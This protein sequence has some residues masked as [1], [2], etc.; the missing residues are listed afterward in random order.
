[1]A[2]STQANHFKYFKQSAKRQ[3]PVSTGKL[4]RFRFF[5]VLEKVP[6]P[7]LEDLPSCGG[8]GGVDD[9]HHDKQNLATRAGETK[10]PHQPKPVRVVICAGRIDDSRQVVNSR[11]G[12]SYT[13]PA[14]VMSKRP[15]QA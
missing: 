15:L 9:S 6:V 3:N 12:E 5:F 8:A 4:T 10:N 1:L 2:A 7:P 11:A 14:Y 13:R